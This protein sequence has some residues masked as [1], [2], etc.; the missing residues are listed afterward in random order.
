MGGGAARPFHPPLAARRAGRGV[1]R[2]KRLRLDY[3]AVAVPLAGMAIGDG[4]IDPVNMI[5]AYPSMLYNLGLVDE[6]ERATVQSYCDRAVA[7]S[8]F[9]CLGCWLCRW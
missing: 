8:R 5:P 9:G 2:L 1:E 3:A 6:R 4:W 7:L